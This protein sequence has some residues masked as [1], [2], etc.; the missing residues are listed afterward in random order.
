MPIS[1]VQVAL[2]NNSSFPIR[3]IDDG[4]P[5]GF[6]QGPWYPSNLKDL[7][8]GVKGTWRLESGGIPLA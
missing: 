4:C 7:M 2:V 8:T 5:Q 6:W 3:W 1:L